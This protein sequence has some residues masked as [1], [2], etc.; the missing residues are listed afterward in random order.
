MK[1]NELQSQ[2]K[3]YENEAHIINSKIYEVK[4]KYYLEK[5]FAKGF[6]IDEYKKFKDRT[7]KI[8][9][10]TYEGGGSMNKNNYSFKIVDA[11]CKL[12]AFDKEFE[13]DCVFEELIVELYDNPNNYFPVCFD[14]LLTK[15]FN[16]KI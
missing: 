13:D 5:L 6:F 8:L 4:T 1:H 15:T 2:L 16:I 14:S 11:D 12:S 9:V 7:G 3:R 10:A